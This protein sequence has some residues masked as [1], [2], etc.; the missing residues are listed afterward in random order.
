MKVQ[1]NI[2]LK[3]IS[4]ML[5]IFKYQL[6]KEAEKN[7]SSVEN[8][9]MLVTIESPFKPRS[10]GA[11]SQ[12]HMLNAIIQQI[13]KETGQDFKST[14]E[15]IKSTAVG[16]GYPMLEKAVR[17]GGQMVMEPVYDWFG[18]VRGI[19]EADSSTEQCAIL[20]DVAIQLAT[21][22]GIVLNLGA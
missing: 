8:L 18:N 16:R 12:N 15:Y 11:N 17:K 14:K 2:R 13:S 19:S 6:R 22:M 1:C 20:I 10:T 3:N 9:E 7:K 5:E 21:E 4:S